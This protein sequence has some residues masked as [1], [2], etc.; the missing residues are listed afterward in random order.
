MMEFRRQ[1]PHAASEQLPHVWFQ[2]EQLP[3]PKTWHLGISCIES[4]ADG[5]QECKKEKVC[6]AIL[7]L[8][9]A[10]AGPPPPA[11]SRVGNFGT[12]TAGFRAH[13]HS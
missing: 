2:A 3:A 6:T 7:Q 4:V 8:Q 10:K 12:P 9:P 13:G 1:H 5:F 11:A